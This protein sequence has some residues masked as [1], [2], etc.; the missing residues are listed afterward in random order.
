MDFADA[1]DAVASGERAPEDAAGD[2]LDRL[3]DG[4]QLGLLDGDTGVVPGLLEWARHGYN[5]TPVVAG[6]VRRLGI[7]G[8]RFAD[9]PRGI[10]LG[11]ST[12]FPVAMA[13]GATWDPELEEEVGAAIG[14]EGLAQ[15]ANLFAGVCVNLLRHPGWGR[16]QETYGEDPVLLG[17]M[18]AGLTRGVRPWLMACV[19][20]FALNSIEDSRFRVDVVVDDDVLREV[21]LPHFR[22]VLDAGAEAVMSAYNSVNGTWCGDNKDLLTGVLRD[23]W[24]FDGFVMSDFVFG[25]RDPVGSVAAGLDLEMPFRQQRAG[26]LPSALADGRLSRDDVRRAGR[27]LLAAQLRWAAAAPAAPP[28]G[29]VVA[30][31][32]HRILAR[33]VA[34]RSMVLL[35]NEPVGG[36]PVLPLDLTALH[37]VA[38]IGRLATAA[39][40]GDAGSSAVHPPSMSSPLDGLREAVSEGVEVVHHDGRDPSSA[41]RLAASADAAVVVVGYTAADE[42]EGMVAMDGATM[43]LLRGPMRLPY[44]GSAAAAVMRGF[45]SASGTRGGDRT[46]LTLHPDDEDLVLAVAAANPRTVVVVVAGSAVLVERWRDA[47]P[48]ILLAWYPGMEGGRALGCVLTGAVEPGGRLP[49]AVPTDP[50]HLPPFDPTATTVRYDRWWGQRRLDRDGHPAAYPLGFGL[51]YTTFRVDSLSVVDVDAE[52][53][54]ARVEVCVTN[55]GDRPG[56]TVVQVYASGDAGPARPRRQLLGFRRVAADPGASTTTNVDLT[57][58]PL[59]C[60]DPARRAWEHVPADYLLEAGQFSGDPDAAVTRLPPM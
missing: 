58:R 16:A 21:Y 54:T 55:T 4:E 52:E 50:A 7:P 23:E 26:I 18:G 34:V 30:C 8:I 5:R 51:G 22:E 59:S 28:P 12:C 9:G 24:G 15:G 2:L 13:R 33:R 32:D 1:V 44:V 3:D 37:R 29:D 48:A 17:R 10:V 35:R 46:G 19:K 6:E 41:A 14:A 40:L 45:G 43:R 56:A 42:G 60:W 39:N 20:H 47:V 53:S 49:F 11:S 36:F 27:R 57:L 38:V 31:A 25:H